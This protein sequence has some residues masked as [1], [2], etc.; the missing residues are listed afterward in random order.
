MKLVVVEEGTS[1]TLEFRQAVVRIGRAID[2]DIR[3]S[4]PLSSRHHCR[5]EVQGPGIWVVDLGS[6]NGTHVN[7]QKVE[8]QQLGVGDVVGVGGARLRLEELGQAPSR[9]GETQ[10]LDG[11][12]LGS[13]G[14]ETLTGESQR[15]R[16]N[17]RVF[18][19]ITRALL[20]ETEL[21]AL[22][23]LIVDATVTLVG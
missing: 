4:G 7:G 11:A 17:L 8:R 3:L 14:L 10:R 13:N 9:A 15:E 19:R 21:P 12:E 22:L 5:I 23:R 1:S 16:G 2:N 18:A 6:A 20:Q